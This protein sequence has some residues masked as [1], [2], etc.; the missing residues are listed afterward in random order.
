M[1]HLAFFLLSLAVAVPLGATAQA[2]D[3]LK[4]DGKTYDIQT[5]PLAP[6]LAANPGRLPEPEVQSTGLWRGYIATW[7]VRDKQLV[8]E[9][10]GVPTRAFMDDVPE[11]ERLRS[12]M[13]ALF[14]KAGPRAATWFTGHLIV[15]T[16]EIVDYVHMGYASTYSS[17]LVL[18]IVKGALQNDRAM[19]REEFEHFRRAQ[20]AAYRKTPQ[21]AESLAEAK[22]GEDRMADEQIEEFLFQVTSAEYLS[23]IFEP[24]AP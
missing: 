7:S 19:N 24:A 13:K 3:V 14:G 15:P 21:Y 11:S 2:P 20:F 4:I 6:F 12:A 17:Y 1:K 10:V 5:N 23:R 22:S 8:L 18:T 16:G 9:D